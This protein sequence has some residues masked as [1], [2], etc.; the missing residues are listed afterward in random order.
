[1]SDRDHH[2]LRCELVHRGRGL[3]TT[4]VRLFENRVHVATP[5]P[6]ANGDQVLVRLRVGAGA[7]LQ[8]EAHVVSRSATAELVLGFV[9]D[10]EAERLRVRQLLDGAAGPAAATT[11]H[12]LVVEDSAIVSELLVFGARREATLRDAIVDVARDGEA[13]WT[14]VQRARY[15]AAVVDFYLPRLTGAE[16]T[17]RIRATPAIAA[18]PIVALSGGG[19]NARRACLAAGAS[20]FV[21]K[22]VTPR[23]LFAVLAPLIHAQER[24]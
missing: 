24:S 2:E 21:D 22:P 13:A 17:R 7:P 18:L 9:F 5:A 14:M 20:A 23:G 6:L 1:V 15:D 16:L 12:L 4:S 11:P 8:L 3:D 19:E 10:G